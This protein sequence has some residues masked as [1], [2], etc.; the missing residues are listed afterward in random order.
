M[1]GGIEKEVAYQVFLPSPLQPT[2]E[3]PLPS[4]VLQPPSPHT[5]SRKAV[6]W[7][8]AGVCLHHSHG[9]I[10]TEQWARRASGRED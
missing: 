5:H 1:R 9:G 2:T 8:F 10:S 4:A 6:S 3:L 7:G